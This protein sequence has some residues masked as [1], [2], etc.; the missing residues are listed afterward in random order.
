MSKEVKI[1]IIGLVVFFATIF[2]INY[3]KKQN[4]FSTNMVITAQFDA[5]DFV[6]VGI[7]VYV[8]GRIVG[9]VVG[10]FKE[11][12]KL[13]LNLDLEPIDILPKNTKASIY[14][15][16]ILGGTAIALLYEETC[17]SN[18][19]ESGDR[20]EGS[21]DG[22]QQT[23]ERTAKPILDKLGAAA[24]KLNND[25]A[26]LDNMLAEAYASV[27]ALEKRTAGWKGAAYKANKTIP[28]TIR[29]LK[30]M[31][32]DLTSNVG[33]NAAQ[34]AAIDSL[35]QTMSNLTQEDIDEMVKVLYTAAEELPKLEPLVNKSTGA[36]PKFNNQIDSVNLLLESYLPGGSNTKITQLLYDEALKDT[37][38]VKIQ[39]MSTTVGD[40]RKNPQKY[41]SLK[42]K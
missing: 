15:E 10:V 30:D 11:G 3:T 26:G 12:E 33:A 22:L 9:K 6:K 35:L 38:Q 7:P 13:Y 28:V 4:L 31:T 17:M 14:S 37:T 25:T 1:G 5:I 19:L 8:R 29:N 27:H 41:L 42:K 2:S 24:D 36:I 40:I 21:L 32:G 34:Q 23:V 16:S 39:G 18:C 20:I